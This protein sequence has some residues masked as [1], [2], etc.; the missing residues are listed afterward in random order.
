MLLVDPFL[1]AIDE[2][3]IVSVCESR[4]SE[5]ISPKYHVFLHCLTPLMFNLSENVTQATAQANSPITV[6]F[7]CDAYLATNKIL[8]A[9]LQTEPAFG[10]LPV[11]YF[12]FLPFFIKS[13]SQNSR[14]YTSLSYFFRTAVDDL[15]ANAF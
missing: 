7:N 2:D 9:M 15:D 14:K 13:C 1:I 8:Y 6:A 11:C 10:L 12:A 4:R 3:Y 5:G